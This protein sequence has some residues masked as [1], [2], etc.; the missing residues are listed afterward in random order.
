MGLLVSGD[1]PG[2][3]SSQNSAQVGD[4]V[5]IPS[6]EGREY[7]FKVTAVRFFRPGHEPKPQSSSSPATN[8]RETV[9]RQP[10]QQQM[11]AQETSIV[12]YSHP[13]VPRP[14]LFDENDRMMPSE[15]QD[16]GQMESRMITKGGTGMRG[17]EDAFRTTSKDVPGPAPAQMG[18]ENFVMRPQAQFSCNAAL[19][20]YGPDGVGVAGSPSSNVQLNKPAATGLFDGDF[21]TFSS[22]QRRFPL[23]LLS[24]AANAERMRPSGMQIDEGDSNHRL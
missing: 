4:V 1:T 5:I 21:E 10:Q 15:T 7:A 11:S 18:P 8:G 16:R 6:P 12:R 19:V 14:K 9:L 22:N 17:V 20:W 2:S 23:P 3:S 24:S 13:A